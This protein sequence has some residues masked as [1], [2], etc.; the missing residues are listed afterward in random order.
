MTRAQASPAPRRSPHA[1][2]RWSA[3]A[4]LVRYR[5][6]LARHG[7]VRARVAPYDAGAMPTPMCSSRSSWQFPLGTDYLGRD[8]LSRIL[9]GT[10]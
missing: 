3:S 6:V 8:M 7:P 5:P 10:R 4:R 1:V 2:R 9:A